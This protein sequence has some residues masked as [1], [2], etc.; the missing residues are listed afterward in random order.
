MPDSKCLWSALEAVTR[1]F[2]SRT[3]VKEVIPS[4]FFHLINR[5]HIIDIRKAIY[6]T[7]AIESL[8]MTLRK[9]LRNH[10]S[11]PTDESAKKSLESS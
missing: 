9:V 1:S 2:L 10:R 11:F 3:H 8:N 7:N 6:T 5:R 4:Q